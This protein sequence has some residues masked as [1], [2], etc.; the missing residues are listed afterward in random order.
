[1]HF[2]W[3]TNIFPKS[4]IY[5]IIPPPNHKG[6]ESIFGKKEEEE[7]GITSDNLSNFLIPINDFCK[8]PFQVYSVI[9]D[10]KCESHVIGEGYALCF[11]MNMAGAAMSCTVAVASG[12]L[13]CNCLDELSRYKR[14]TMIKKK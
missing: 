14:Q 3:Y 1:M 7:D 2:N 10:P 13:V 6:L 5:D 12:I 8:D 9:I 11:G 4:F